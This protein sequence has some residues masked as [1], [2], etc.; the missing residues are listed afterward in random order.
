MLPPT[1]FVNQVQTHDQVGN[2]PFG[3]RLSALVPEAVLRAAVAVCLL[4]PAPPMLFMG[5]EFS[6]AQPFLFFCDFADARIARS[7]RAG[8]NRSHA[9]FRGFE[10]AALDARHPD[11]TVEASFFASRLDWEACA[12]PSHARMHAHYSALLELRRRWIVPLLPKIGGG[13]GSW[14]RVGAHALA[15]TWAM[16]DGRCLRQVANLGP[17]PCPTDAL[18]AATIVY[19]PDGFAPGG[20][21]DATLP[22]WSVV[23]AIDR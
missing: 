7:V 4:A 10:D 12:R 5:E 2:R 11:P 22:P 19:A 15:V 13:A 16:T 18:P 20:A 1:V 9:R 6:A 8:R 17:A 23:V 3:E 14:H 21:G